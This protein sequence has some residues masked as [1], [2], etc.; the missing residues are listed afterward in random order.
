MEEEGINWW[1]TPAESPDINPI[2]NLWHESKEYLR[3]EI[4]PNT[5][6]QLIS[7]IETFWGTVTVV[8]CRKYVIHLK[9]VVPKVIELNGG[10]TGY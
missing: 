7:G 5:K 9:K 10:P 6:E 1:K 8:K 3:R 2:E 4:K